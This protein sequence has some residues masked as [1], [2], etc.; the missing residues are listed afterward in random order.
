MADYE[1]PS[2]CDE[3]NG[4]AS[5]RWREEQM[6]EAQ[7]AQVGFTFRQIGFGPISGT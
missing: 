6:M 1:I 5:N 3:D 7:E 4:S 2:L